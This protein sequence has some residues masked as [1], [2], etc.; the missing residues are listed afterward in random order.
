M[1]NKTIL[2]A[3]VF[4]VASISTHALSLEQ[5]RQMA[6]DHYPAIRQYR[7]I[8]QSRDFTLANAVKGWLPKV[9][10]SANASAFTDVLNR[11]D[12]MKMMGVDMENW[13]AS[14][15]VTVTQSVYD[16][17]QI[18]AQKKVISA[19]AEVQSRQLDVSM[20]AVYERVEQIF[21]GILLID[22]QL[23]QNKLLLLDLSSSENTIRSM[24]KGGLANQGDLET[25]QVEKLKVSQ[26]K[27]TLLASREAYCRMLGVFV[28]KDLPESEPLEKP[29]A[30]IST[31]P[32]HAVNRP[33][34]A[35]YSSQEH[36]LDTQLKQL[37]TRL[38]PTVSIFG[39][40]MA[41]TRVS[42]LLNDGMLVGGLSLSWNIG[43]LYTRKNDI[44]KLETQRAINDSQRETFLFQNRLQNEE[45]DG[46]IAS[47]QKQIACDEDIV[48]LR[49]NI[50]NKGEHRMELGTESVSELVREINA[51]SIAKA[52]KAQHEIELLREIYRQK[53]INNE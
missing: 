46:A 19:Q 5:A 30:V 6:R 23:E 16:G 10:V 7:L 8:E 32:N 27:E 1:N 12:Q 15:A 36:L 39:M 26:Q 50:R 3:A 13:M 41:H 28:G 49:E 34:L 21:F 14:G 31:T 35:Y 2:L 52:Q 51:V 37:D 20:Y 42:S 33:E 29:S 44:R 25:I 43:A 40:G 4:C 38:R 45:A 17:G 11:S 22:E 9:S 18:A 48:R 24:I 47:M 53:R